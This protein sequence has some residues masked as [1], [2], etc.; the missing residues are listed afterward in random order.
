MCALT[1]VVT[2]EYDG[3]TYEWARAYAR[4]HGLNLR[5]VL[6]AALA[7]YAAR[8]QQTDTG[9]EP[10]LHYRRGHPSA[11]LTRRQQQLMRGSRRGRK[12]R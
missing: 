3:T 9:P 8:R 2:S 1:A 12:L 7:E 5:S 10:Q 11:E 4:A 6:N